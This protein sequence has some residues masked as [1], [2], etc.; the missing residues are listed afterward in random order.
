MVHVPA[1]AGVRSTWI[2]LLAFVL[3][4]ALRL[5]SLVQPAGGDQGLYAYTG[6][7]LVAGDVPYRDVWDQ[8]PPA[9]GAVYA[10]LTSVWPHESVVAGAD[11]LLAGVVAWSLVLIG[12]RR[13]SDHVGYAAAALLL[14]FGNPSLQRLSGIYVR[15]Q[16]E[17]FI[18]CAIT[19]ALLALS[20][21]HRTRVRLILAGA[22]LAL[23]I[24]LKYNAVAYALP[25]LAAIQ[26]WPASPSPWSSFPRGLRWVAL[27][28]LAPSAAV[29]AY[30]AV[31][32]AL[33]DL[34]LATV[35][36]NLRYSEETYATPLSVL[37]YVVQLPFQRVRVDMLWFL[38]GLGSVIL[39]GSSTARAAVHTRVLIAWLAA[40]VLSIAINGQRDL[41]N[42][43]VQAAPALALAAAAGIERALRGPR[44]ERVAVVILLLAGL[45]RV[46]TDAPVAGVRLGALPD[47]VR[48]IQY[49]LSYVRGD[50]DRRTYLSRFRGQKHD[51]LEIDDLVRYLRET[52]V[53]EDRVFVF[54]FSGGSVGWKSG[55]A[56][57]T[58]FFW[59]MPV[60]VGFVAGR[61]GYG[62]AGL[63]ADLERR[64]PAVVVLQREQWQSEAFFLAQG[65]LRTWLQ[66]TYRL[67]RE[68]PMF[69]IWRR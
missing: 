58:R 51:A 61:P 36:Y 46:G 9:I 39:L 57:P 2:W 44:A 23:A 69:S 8:K 5:P 68:T 56:S 66:G 35:D 33:T 25:I 67:E 15:G 11:L 20:H 1:R 49:D 41:P 48:N 63:L 53:A 47:L 19:V 27:G 18:A 32:G 22:S 55:R 3:L 40:C 45:W 43:F 54:G 10:L 38:G 62:P 29:L 52:T 24:W 37:V 4:Y 65:P 12:R 28:V 16:C 42:Y 64:P 34:R 50:L 13:F 30:F 14:L 31:N 17:P 21:G 26:W 60:I 7:R 59:S 6:Q